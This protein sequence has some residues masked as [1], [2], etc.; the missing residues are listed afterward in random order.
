[1]RYRSAHVEN[2]SR[3]QRLRALTPKTIERFTEIFDPSRRD[4]EITLDVIGP[5]HR[6]VR[7][8]GGPRISVVCESAGNGTTLI[9][10][11]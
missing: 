6:F 4:R 1:M 3:K 11:E 2:I 5:N 10:E 7:A 9:A 8:G